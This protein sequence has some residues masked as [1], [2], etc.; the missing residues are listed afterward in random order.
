MT[1]MNSKGFEIVLDIRQHILRVRVWGAWDVGFV[2]KYK[3]ALR[4]KIEEI[5]EGDK[6]WYALVDFT[7]FYPRSEEVQDMMCDQIATAGEQGMKKIACLGEE[8]VSQLRLN[9]LF[10]TSNLQMSSFAESEEEAIQWLL[11]E[12]E[13]HC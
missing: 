1:A 5:R 10:L 7:G 3:S 4:E 8:S 9:K 12:S 6:E 11:N 2:K 13:L